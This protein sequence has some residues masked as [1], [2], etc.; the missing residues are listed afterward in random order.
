MK[1][2]C[3]AAALCCGLPAGRFGLPRSVSTQPPRKRTL[4]LVPVT[5]GT[6][7]AVLV[8]LV[9]VSPLSSNICPPQIGAADMV[10]LKVIW[11]YM[12]SSRLLRADDR[13]GVVRAADDLAQGLVKGL[14]RRVLGA[15]D[16]A[17]AG[18]ALPGL[19]C[20]HHQG[21][22]HQSE[23]RQQPEDNQQECAA[24]GDNGTIDRHENLSSLENK[25]E[26]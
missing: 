15:V 21:D 24:P 22:G 6:E 14:P 11:S 18:C 26:G 25:D 17:D 13:A 2:L 3:P 19:V 23:H 16:E 4:E 20:Q 1:V 5:L 12:V 9:T 7:A 10:A 8:R